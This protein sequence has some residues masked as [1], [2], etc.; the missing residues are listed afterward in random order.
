MNYEANQIRIKET[1]LLKDMSFLYAAAVEKIIS[2]KQNIAIYVV[3]IYNLTLQGVIV[4]YHTITQ[5]ALLN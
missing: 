5:L 3:F 4:L 1:Y 2:K